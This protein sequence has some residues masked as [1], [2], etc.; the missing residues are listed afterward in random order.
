MVRNRNGYWMSPKFFAM[1]ATDSGTDTGTGNSL[2]VNVTDGG[3]GSGGTETTTGA[4]DIGD[5]AGD[6]DQNGGDANAEI[7]KLRAEVAK[8]KKAI[9][10]ATKEAANYKRELRKKQSA[11][12]IAAEEKK[13]Q[14]E[15]TKLELENL[16]KEVAMAKTVKTVMSR[17]GTDETASA[18]IAEYLYGSED[19]EAALTE[20]SKAWTAKE[21]AL[22]LE[23]GRVPPPGAGGA[24]GEDQ[25]MAAAIK[26]AKEMG[27]RKAQNTASVREQLGGLVR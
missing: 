14:D 20:I 24:N 16:R 25:E 1:A 26:F 19:A 10:D 2:G 27:Q 11:E 12:E 3:A 9:D 17:L 4:A 18:K 8:Q 5:D 22:K 23:Y 7:A 15:A 13:T 21:K 6:D